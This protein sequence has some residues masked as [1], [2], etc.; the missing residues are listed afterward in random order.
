[1][2]PAE[3]AIAGLK[4]YSDFIAPYKAHKARKK[5]AK[6]D[7]VQRMLQARRQRVA[8]VQEAQYITASNV[9]AA[10]AEG[11]TGSSADLGAAAAIA[12][13]AGANQGFMSG[14]DLFGNERARQEQK[15]ADYE[16]TGA[17]AGSLANFSGSDAGRAAG[18]KIKTGAT[19][20]KGLFE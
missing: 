5:A 10:A 8:A 16:F 11:T 1:M 9:A 17:M 14:F 4:V 2:T 6:A 20:V 15:A 3:V 18:A 12:S 7:Q 19:K 13:Q